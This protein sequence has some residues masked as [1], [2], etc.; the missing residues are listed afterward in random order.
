MDFVRANKLI[1]DNL[2]E[3]CKSATVAFRHLTVLIVGTHTHI[4]WDERDIKEYEKH[5]R[6]HA[7]SEK[8]EV[9]RS[10]DRFWKHR[11]CIFTGDES[12]SATEPC[13][14]PT[15]R[16]LAGAMADMYLAESWYWEKRVEWLEAQEQDASLRRQLGEAKRMVRQTQ[17]WVQ[18]AR[19]HLI[20]VGGGEE[21][22]EADVY[23][24]PEKWNALMASWHANAFV[25]LGEIAQRTSAAMVS[26]VI[27][28]VRERIALDHERESLEWVQHCEKERLAL[29]QEQ[30]AL[31][32]K[33][34]RLRTQ[35]KGLQ[36]PSPP[37]P[38][39]PSP[40]EQRDAMLARLRKVNAAKAAQNARKIA[41]QERV[42]KELE[43]QE[44][45]ARAHAKHKARAQR[46]L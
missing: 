24:D 23:S 1:I 46:E 31:D 33:M 29:D 9:L 32:L 35:L 15:W 4:P 16:R 25:W 21:D 10:C 44:R 8:R 41:E 36:A 19:D 38:S 30:R 42:A 7:L 27:L 34:A 13:L 5:M 40:E 39:A 28:T 22:M 6:A 17:A 18:D 2:L 37:P 26:R 12:A 11:F 45:Q 43:A 14:N 20:E 3:R